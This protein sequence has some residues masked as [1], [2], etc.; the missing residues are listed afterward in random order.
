[1]KLQLLSR[2]GCRLLLG[3]MAALLAVLGVYPVS[4][5]WTV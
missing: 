2:W 3:A 5:S 4:A 1:M